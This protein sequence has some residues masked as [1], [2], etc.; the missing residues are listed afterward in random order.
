MIK[1]R[2]GIVRDLGK[3]LNEDWA[4][5]GA[6]KIQNDYIDEYKNGSREFLTVE[7]NG[8]IVGELWIFWDDKKDQEQ[9]NGKNRAY[10]STLR[11][12]PDYRR[13]GIGTMLINKAIE[14]IKKTDYKEVTIAA[15][16]HEP[17]IQSLY[18]KWG[19]TEIIKEGIE[20]SDEIRRE[21]I[22]FLKKL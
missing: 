9:A 6:K 17:E 2:K 20:I 7:D 18:I 3:L 22:L 14:L 15:Y 1:I 5:R 13:R 8:E 11:L 16:K 21:Y 19:F 4:W 10:L 12:H